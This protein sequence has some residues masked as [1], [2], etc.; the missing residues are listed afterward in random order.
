MNDISWLVVAALVIGLFW[1][2]TSVGR[3]LDHRTD[4][5]AILWCLKREPGMTGLEIAMITGISRT[6]VYVLLSK[7]EDKGLVRREVKP[8]PEFPIEVIR[9]YAVQP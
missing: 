8:H 5:G 2:L 4:E 7:M 1:T 9:F 3:H 6:A